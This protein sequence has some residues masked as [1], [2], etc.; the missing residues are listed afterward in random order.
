M[1]GDK[2]KSAEK[3]G[4]NRSHERKLKF[5]YKE[6]KEYGTIEQDIAELE[7]KIADKETE[8]GENASNSLLLQRLCEEQDAL[9]RQLP[10]KLERWMYLEELAAKIA[11]Q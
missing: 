4:G 11:E 9:N 3:D 1:K 10:D 8:I 2:R 5:S 6:Q 7:K